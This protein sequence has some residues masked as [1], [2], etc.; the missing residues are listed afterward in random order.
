MSTSP[1]RK[2]L[3]ILAVF[4]VGFLIIRYLG[5]VLM[6][7][8]LGT[9]IAFGAEPA[10]SLCVRKLRL[11]RPLSAGL[12]VSVTL[13]LLFATLWLI[14]ALAVKEMGQLAGAMPNVQSTVQQGLTLLQDWLIGIANR[15]PD[16]LGTLLTQLVTEL[17]GSS[18]AFLS[19]LI[20]RLPGFFGNLL[21]WVPS[22]AIGLITGILAGFM[23]SV[24]LPQLR[25]LFRSKIPQKWRERYQPALV[26]LRKTL[27]AWLKAQL[28]MMGITY[29]IVAAGLFLSG[30]SYGPLWALPV[31]IV[32][33][34]P[35]L[36][37][38]TVLIPWAIIVILQGNTFQAIGL[39]IT[40][41]AA[42][43]A[44]TTLEPRLVGKQ[45]GL[46]PLVT[47]LFFYAGYKLFGVLGML[48]APMLA[49]AAKSLTEQTSQA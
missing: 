17:F 4:L 28:K 25:E 14:G 42:V 34:V 43:L 21:S 3:T 12:G 22:G 47:L 15:A 32:D 48:F 35:V 1:V 6:P 24:R 31:A 13:I 11:P 27:G 36:G 5:P 46:D 16:G 26:K 9:L 30:V 45:L 8:L 2:V 49:A 20:G 18:S 23:I 44:R 29:V 41:G 38:G 33:A 37:T 10:V 39:F 19:R 7:F 40:Y